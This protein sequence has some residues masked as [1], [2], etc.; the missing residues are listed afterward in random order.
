MKLHL[1]H[2]GLSTLL[3]L[4]IPLILTIRDGGIEGVGWNWKLGDFIIMGILLFGTGVALD[5]ARQ[6][7][8]NPTHRILAL[9]AI[10]GAFLL[11]WVEL[12][13]D[14]VS[15]FLQFLLG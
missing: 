3:L 7:V 1:T 8:S 13:V 4:C 14:A 11:I 12:A 6:K 5:Y 15:K 9:C 2:I 10:V